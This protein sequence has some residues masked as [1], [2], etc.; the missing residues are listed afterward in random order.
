MSEL[1][2]SD[3]RVA[4]HE[5]GHAVVVWALGRG[6][7]QIC[8]TGQIGHRGHTCADPFETPPEGMDDP[9]KQQRWVRERAITYSIAGAVAEEIKFGDY[10]EEPARHD[11]GDLPYGGP[12]RADEREHVWAEATRYLR[13]HWPA[14]EALVPALVSPPMTLHGELVEE[15]IQKALDPEVIRRRQSRCPWLCD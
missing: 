15:I 13:D 11:E 1:M 2:E 7:N 5:A 9:A 6:I 10:N 3:R 12:L 8:I 14:V 4:Y